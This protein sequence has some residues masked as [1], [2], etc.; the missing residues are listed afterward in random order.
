MRGPAA[1]TENNL[2]VTRPLAENEKTMK[3][4]DT[5]ARPFKHL[6]LLST[7]QRRGVL[8]RRV[9]EFFRGALS[10]NNGHQKCV[11]RGTPFPLPFPTPCR[12]KNL[13]EKHRHEHAN[14][15]AQLH[16]CPIYLHR[17]R[18]L[19]RGTFQRLGARLLG[20]GSPA[21]V[22]WKRGYNEEKNDNPVNG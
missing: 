7:R 17:A 21:R 6:S 3:R 8:I 11:R 22:R 15:H 4:E 5:L 19:L 1:P 14:A 2:G 13:K 10:I 18:Q 16:T 9:N 12:P 20:R